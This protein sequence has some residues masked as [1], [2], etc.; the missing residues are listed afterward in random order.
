MLLQ[1]FW[2]A[3]CMTA[4]PPTLFSAAISGH[5]V[6]QGPGIGR[7]QAITCYRKAKALARFLHELADAAG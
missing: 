3:S 2:P 5:R 6:R 1:L 7:Q 4:H